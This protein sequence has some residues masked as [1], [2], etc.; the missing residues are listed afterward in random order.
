MQNSLTCGIDIAAKAS[1]SVPFAVQLHAL[2]S[3]PVGGRAARSKARR[4]A[5][6]LGSS[7]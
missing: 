4:S 5:Q 3:M 6:A 7:P 1:R 2:R